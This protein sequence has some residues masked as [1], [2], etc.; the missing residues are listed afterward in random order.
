M[1]ELQDT[2]FV[3][4]RLNSTFMSLIP[5]KEGYKFVS[6]VRP[7]S[8]LSGAYKSCQSISR[9]FGKGDGKVSISVTNGGD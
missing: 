9:S 8:L 7:I 3:N 2:M 6:V 5:K 4:W 1:R